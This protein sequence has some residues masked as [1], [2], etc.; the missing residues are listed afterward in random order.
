MK[1]IPIIMLSSPQGKRVLNAV[2]KA[3]QGRAGQ[4]QVIVEKILADVKA[5]GDAA[6]FAYTKK[7]D[8]VSIT[9]KS[10]RLESSYIRKRAALAPQAFKRSCAE[11][12]KRIRAFH[13]RQKPSIFTMKT[14]EGTLSQIVRPIRRAGV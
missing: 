3:R 11:A 1:K 8:K 9:K 7:F 13:E 12:A 6:L 2:K 10:I 14:A 4:A 5:R